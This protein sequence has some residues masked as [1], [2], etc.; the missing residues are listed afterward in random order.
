MSFLICS[1]GGEYGGG[2]CLGSAGIGQRIEKSE[3]SFFRQVRLQPFSQTI[4]S[5]MT[6]PRLCRFGLRWP[7]T[8]LPFPTTYNQNAN[9]NVSQDRP[10]I[11]FY[12]GFV[13]FHL[14]QHRVWDSLLVID[15]MIFPLDFVVVDREY[16]AG[17]WGCEFPGGIVW[18][19]AGYVFSREPGRMFF[20]VS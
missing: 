6:I 16:G 17:G 5:F 12:R 14:R 18:D 1:Y 11:L 7:D 10:T 13:R 19:N 20:Q 2:K 4:K 9:G 8:A 15:S 3:A